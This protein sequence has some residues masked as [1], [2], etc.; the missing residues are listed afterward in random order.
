MNYSLKNS[1]VIIEK[2]NGIYNAMNKGI[3][4]SSCDY[5]LF[6]NSGDYFSNSS[7]LSSLLTHLYSFDLVYG[8]I[9]DC[10]QFS[11]KVVSYPNKLS[12][13]YMLCG[14]LPHQATAIRRSL[15]ESVGLYAEKYKIISDWV[16]FMDALFIHNASYK[17]IPVVV[18]KFEGNGLSSI[19]ENTSLIVYEQI[20]YI[21]FKFPNSLFYYYNNSPYV[22]K[23]LRQKPKSLRWLFKFALFKFNKVF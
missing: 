11:K 22:K 15:F 7:S 2:D 5:L 1:F 17:H 4:K 3:I 19:S 14:G 16:F 12:F 21:S 10:G 18:S 6:L 20:D 9:F 23:Y 13:E 8:D